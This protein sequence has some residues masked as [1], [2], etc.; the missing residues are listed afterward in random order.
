MKKLTSMPIPIGDV[1]AQSCNEP[2]IGLG[3]PIDVFVMLKAV[4]LAISVVQ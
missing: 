3:D 1:G 2:F 4:A